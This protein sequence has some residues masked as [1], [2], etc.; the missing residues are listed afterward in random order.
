MAPDDRPYHHGDLPA[1]LLAAVDE[2]VRE[3]GAAALTL[4]EVARRAGVSHAAPAHHFGDKAGLLT[5]YATEGMHE[6]AT[7]MA[8]ARTQAADPGGVDALRLLTDTLGRLAVAYVAFAVEQPARFTVMFG[9]EQLHT[10]DPLYQAATEEA[11]EQLYAAVLEVRRD[12]Q[13]DDPELMH[14]ASGAWSV[15][16]GFATLWL[17][18]H[19]DERVTSVPPEQATAAA[20]GAFG[21]TLFAAAGIT[22]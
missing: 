13:R 20:L 18:G 11:F 5:A 7:R 8:A 1:A 6:M 2:V 3:R 14:A 21:T 4:R 16:H 19:L 17:A 22:P 15:V 10:D 9:S 12:L